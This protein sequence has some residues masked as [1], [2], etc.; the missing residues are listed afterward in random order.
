MSAAV[1]WSRDRRGSRSRHGRRRTDR[2]RLQVASGLPAILK[3][4]R[5]ALP[6]DPD[7]EKRTYLRDEPVCFW[8]L[9]AVKQGCDEN[10]RGVG[11][12]TLLKPCRDFIDKALPRW[13]HLKKPISR[14]MST[15][16]RLGRRIGGGK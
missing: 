15:G 2:K 13:T 14:A 4:Q 7:W 12:E 9:E 11:R 16:A 6:T 8:V 1:R 3:L 5:P 10:F